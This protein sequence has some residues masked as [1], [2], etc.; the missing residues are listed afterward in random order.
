[1]SW[2]AA[3]TTAN[4]VLY[5][6]GW[7]PVESKSCIFVGSNNVPLGTMLTSYEMGNVKTLRQPFDV[8]MT[9][10]F[11]V[12]I[13]DAFFSTWTVS[14]DVVLEISNTFFGARSNGVKIV[15]VPDSGHS[16]TITCSNLLLL[17]VVLLLF[18][19][20]S[21]LLLLLELLALSCRSSSGVKTELLPVDVILDQTPDVDRGNDDED[22]K[23][24]L[25]IS[26][27]MSAARTSGDKEVHASKTEAGRVGVEIEPD[28]SR[29]DARASSDDRFCSVLIVMVGEGMDGIRLDDG[30]V[31]LTG[32]NEIIDG[33]C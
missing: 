28:S 25:D 12:T 23:T 14:R 16:S 21:S 2:T 26:V 18:P 9:V 31:E 10:V 29:I 13:D 1:M 3:S 20:S 17:V 19:L 4:R 33:K 6:S 5:P 32:L 15:V 24:V 11:V 22:A 8:V 7:T 30:W 27:A